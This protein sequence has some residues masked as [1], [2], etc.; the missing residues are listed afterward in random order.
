M[1]ERA[2]KGYEKYK[3]HDKQDAIDWL[4]KVEHYAKNGF[5]PFEG[6]GVRSKGSS[7]PGVWGV[8]P[9]GLFRFYG[10]YEQPQKN[11]F[12]AIGSTMKDGQK[13]TDSDKD[14]CS[15]VLKIMQQGIWHK[16]EKDESGNQGNP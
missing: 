4:D 2:K 11:D 12:I 13:M 16:R 6:K 15:Y 10:F 3:K 1:S 9:F 5:M 8:Q 7:W 14:E